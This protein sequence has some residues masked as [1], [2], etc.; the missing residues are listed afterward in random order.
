MMDAVASELGLNRQTLL[1]RLRAEGVT[2]AKLLD[3]ARRAAAIESLRD[4]GL[5]VK[6]AVFAA[7][8]SDPA[9]FSRAFKRWMGEPPRDF[10]ARHALRRRR[11]R[12]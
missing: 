11:S 8:F 4:R 10:V 3:G 6:E 5:P 7:G 9:P 12:R 1:R 2:L